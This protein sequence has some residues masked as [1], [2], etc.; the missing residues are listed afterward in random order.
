MGDAGSMRRIETAVR[1]H[2]KNVTLQM[3]GIRAMACGIQWP[4]EIQEKSGCNHIAAMQA[5]KTAMSQHGDN[6]DLQST[7]LEAIAKYL[8]HIKCVEEVKDKGGE[9]LVKAMMTRH[10]QVAKV[11]KWGKDVLDAIGSNKWTPKGA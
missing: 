8:E 3:K 1:T 6:A 11:Q 4:H 7:A 5:C 10:M 9:G 2:V